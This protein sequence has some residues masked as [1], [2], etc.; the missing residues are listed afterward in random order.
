MPTEKPW[1]IQRRD[2]WRAEIARRLSHLSQPMVMGLAF[3][4]V[5]PDRAGTAARYL[6]RRQG[7]SWWASDPARPEIEL[8]A[9]AGN[10]AIAFLTLLVD[11]NPWLQDT[12]FANQPNIS[13]PVAAIQLPATRTAIRGQPAGSAVT[14]ADR[15]AVRKKIALTAPPSASPPTPT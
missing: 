15:M 3:R 7:K 13:K 2:R 14:S 1:I 12:D 11:Q 5:A 9:V 4:S 6:S 8:G 10:G